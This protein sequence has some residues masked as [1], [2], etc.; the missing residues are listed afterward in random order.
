[1]TSYSISLRASTL[2]TSFILVKHAR[3][4]MPFTT[5]ETPCQ[6]HTLS[7]LAFLDKETAFYTVTASYAYYRVK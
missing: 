7:R 1:M 3:R 2:T 6:M 4:F 5:E